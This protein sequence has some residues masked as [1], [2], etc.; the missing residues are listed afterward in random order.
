MKKKNI[1]LPL[2]SIITI[3]LIT[4]AVVIFYATR[5][6]VIPKSILKQINF[7]IFYPPINQQTTIETST[8]KY[9]KSLGQVSF[10]VNFSGQH[11]TFAE[12]SS[13]DSFAADPNF[14]PAFVQKLG[15]YATFTSV[16]GRV[17]LARPAQVDAETGIMNAK[18]TL[19]FVKSTS[20]LSENNWKLL[21]N[22]LTYAQPH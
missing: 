15:G 7:A 19:L 22:S 18:G 21:F 16:N 17:D 11:I 13:P 9:A 10:I 2:V 6:P 4:V 12:Q 5:P 8:F 1:S 3:V 14:Y 20:N